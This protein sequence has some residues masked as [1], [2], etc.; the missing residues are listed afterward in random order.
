MIKNL[1]FKILLIIGFLI[2]NLVH[3]S[4]SSSKIIKLVSS[5]P[6]ISG[7]TFT[8]L[9]NI[10]GK[11]LFEIENPSESIQNGYCIL[12]YDLKLLEKF[13]EEIHPK[14]KSKYILITKSCCKSFKKEFLKYLED[15]QLAVWI[16]I[17]IKYD[18]PRLICMPIGV[19]SS[20]S[21]K[22][23]K[24]LNKVCSQDIDLREKF[25]NKDKQFFLYSNFSLHTHKSR[26]R[27]QK[28]FRDKKFCYSPTKKS[29]N[30]YL[31]D[32]TQSKFVLSPRG[33]GFDCFKTW[34]T[35]SCGSIPIVKSSPIDYLYEDLPVLIINEWEE[36]TEEFLNEKF[37][38]MSKKEYNLEKIY[39]DYWIN[40]IKELS[41]DLKSTDS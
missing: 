1:R 37:E 34:E 14:I 32:L 30:L 29:F 13:L 25:F 27:I 18:H 7:E 31:Q 12:F 15:D 2:S 23:F 21:P 11:D 38:D 35:L 16:G 24:L 8:S 26:P 10:K 17:N 41:E 22:Q 19:A 33:H 39:A 9:C 3:K 36:I 20:T 5:Y 4:K 28:F 6:Y 40:L